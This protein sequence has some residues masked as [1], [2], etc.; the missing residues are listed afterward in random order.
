MSQITH[1]LHVCLLAIDL[2][3][4]KADKISQSD[5]DGTENIISFDFVITAIKMIPRYD[6]RICQRINR[7]Y[8][9]I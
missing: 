7:K 9:S 8:S 1:R 3:S 5:K 6:P 4:L 2:D